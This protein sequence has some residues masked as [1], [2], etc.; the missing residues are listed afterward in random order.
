MSESQTERSEGRAIAGAAELLMT[1]VSTNPGTNLGSVE[2]RANVVETSLAT[3][4]THS[5][6]LLPVVSTLA[7]STPLSWTE[8]SAPSTPYAT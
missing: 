7:G 6:L 8:A 5:S 1:V 3:L 4:P 2:V